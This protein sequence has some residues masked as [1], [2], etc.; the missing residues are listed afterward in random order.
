MADA[1]KSLFFWRCSSDL[2]K[3]GDGTSGSGP[4]KIWVAPTK[5]TSSTRTLASDRTASGTSLAQQVPA[6]VQHVCL[7]EID[8]EVSSLVDKIHQ[9]GGPNMRLVV[10]RTGENTFEV[11]GRQVRL[12]KLDVVL[13]VTEDIET[14]GPGIPLERYLRQAAF[15]STALRGLSD[16]SPLV[17]QV[18]ADQRLSFMDPPSCSEKASVYRLKSMRLACEQA[19]LREQAAAAYVQGE[20]W[21][22]TCGSDLA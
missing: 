6:V 20:F 17:A 18:P 8:A 7:E 16:G 13:M 1:C 19:R 12:S 10:R 14:S 22:G 21:A 15:I 9:E 2:C 5:P 4:E 3:A 11:E